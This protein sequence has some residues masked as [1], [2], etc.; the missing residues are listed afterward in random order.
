MKKSKHASAQSSNE[1]H[2]LRFVHVVVLF[3]L[4]EDVY[5]KNTIF[6]FVFFERRQL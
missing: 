5:I 4:T 6:R 2:T 3:V 1:S